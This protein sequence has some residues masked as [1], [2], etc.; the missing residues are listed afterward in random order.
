MTSGAR[1]ILL[2]LLILGTQ[3]DAQTPIHNL[4]S[5]TRGARPRSELHSE[6]ASADSALF[7]AFNQRDITRFRSH[8]SRDLEFYQD[9]EGVENYA[10]TMKDFGKMF[11]QPAPIRRELVPGSLEV[12]PIKDYGAIEVGRHR[13]CHVENG[14]NDCGTFSFVHIWRRT[15]AGWKVSRVVSY[16]H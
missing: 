1:T 15:K 2:A 7:T 10:Q 6:I 13:F 11:G 5:V 12:Y 16:G 3:A 14:K 8:F 9:N 4:T